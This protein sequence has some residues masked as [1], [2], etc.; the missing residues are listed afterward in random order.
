M[1][2]TPMDCGMKASSGWDTLHWIVHLNAFGFCS[3]IGES[4]ESITVHFNTLNAT[5]SLDSSSVIPLGKVLWGSPCYYR[6]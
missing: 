5:V 1:P 2:G 6:E 3:S 4:L